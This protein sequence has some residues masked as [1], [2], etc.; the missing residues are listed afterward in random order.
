M[1][2]KIDSIE[3]EID[4]IRLKI[5]EETKDMTSEQ[6]NEYFRKKTEAVIKEYGIRVVSSAN[7]V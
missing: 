1:G 3:R 7:D 4:E 2:R 5:Y 6:F